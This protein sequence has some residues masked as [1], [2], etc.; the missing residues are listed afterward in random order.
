MT[1]CIVSATIFTKLTKD[2]LKETYFLTKDTLKETYFL[3]WLPMSWYSK[4]QL[5]NDYVHVCKTYVSI[6]K[7]DKIKSLAS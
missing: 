6:C 7:G 5:I 4:C 2:T 3:Q 1:F